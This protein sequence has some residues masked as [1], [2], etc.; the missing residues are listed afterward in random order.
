MVVELVN[1][2]NITG[3]DT[4]TLIPNQGTPHTLIAPV[5]LDQSLPAQGSLNS[6]NNGAPSP[7]PCPRQRWEI[8]Y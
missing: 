5:T 4:M 3:A 1:M 2:L 6:V 8:N 7:S